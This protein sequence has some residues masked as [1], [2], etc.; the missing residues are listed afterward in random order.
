MALLDG[1]VYHTT[2]LHT[3]TDGAP[4]SQSTVGHWFDPLRPTRSPQPAS[5]G[6]LFGSLPRAVISA[7]DTCRRL[8]RRG[9]RFGRQIAGGRCRRILS[10]ASKEEAAAGSVYSSQWN[11]AEITRTVAAESAAGSVIL[12]SSELSGP[13]KAGTTQRCIAQAAGVFPQ[14]CGAL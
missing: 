8:P 7:P 12:T 14:H 1:G 5:G 6:P 11:S 13:A 2:G 3:A 4:E 10:Y 9:C